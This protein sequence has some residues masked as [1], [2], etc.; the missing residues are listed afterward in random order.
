MARTDSASRSDGTW[1]TT[2]RLGLVRG[3]DVIPVRAEQLLSRNCTYGRE[4]AQL[5]G[6][7]PLVLSCAKIRTRH[8]TLRKHQVALPPIRGERPASQIRL[9]GQC[10]SSSGSAPPSCSS[11]PQAPAR[12]ADGVERAAPRRPAYPKPVENWQRVAGPT[13]RDSAGE[14]YPKRRRSRLR[15]TG[16]PYRLPAS[17]E[18]RAHSP[19]RRWHSPGTERGTKTSLIAS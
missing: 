10:P 6:G 13:G 9:P 7:P 1:G 2:A 15:S 14:G 19:D 16:C 4:G 17:P 12:W 5:R 11:G 3:E 18:F 8:F